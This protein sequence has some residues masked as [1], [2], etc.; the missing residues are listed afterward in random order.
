M[1]PIAPAPVF[2]LSL[3]G[4]RGDMTNALHA[5]RAIGLIYVC[6]EIRHRHCGLHF[7]ESLG[8]AI[9]FQHCSWIS[10]K[11]ASSNNM[12]I[13]IGPVQTTHA[14]STHPGLVSAAR[15]NRAIGQQQVGLEAT[16]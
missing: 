12:L 14:H 15:I 4:I 5:L 11:A 9:S 7:E 10:G 1:P 8:A 6:A 2:L 13:D 16:A 3:A